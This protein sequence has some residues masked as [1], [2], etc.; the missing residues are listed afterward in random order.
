ME[1]MF[2]DRNGKFT[3][4]IR[5]FKDSIWLPN[6]QKTYSSLD[7]GGGIYSGMSTLDGRAVS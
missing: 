2:P 1:I 7:A 4:I 3:S 6:Y 5:K